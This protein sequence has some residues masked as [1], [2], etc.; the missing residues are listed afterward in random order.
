MDVWEH[1]FEK[2]ASFMW[3]SWLLIALLGL[4]ILYTL[5]TGFVQV[6]CF[7]LVIK[8]FIQSINSRNEEKANGKCSSYQALCTAVASCVGSGN[9]VGVSTAILSGGPGALFWMWVAAFFGMATKFGEIILGICYHGEDENKQIVGGPMYYIAHAL[10]LKWIGGLV[11]VLLF[12]QNAGATLI[13]S[14]TISGVISEGFHIPALLTGIGLAVLMALV[15]RGGFRSLVHVAKKIVPVM[16]GLYV[17][18]GL[19]VLLV[20]ATGFRKCFSRFLPALFL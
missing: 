6:R 14:N 16:A 11:A 7:P 8:N 15:I 12:I 2:I 18:G 13:Q 1:L 10:K 19:I 5:I 3:D 9:I 17:A 4:G 20:M